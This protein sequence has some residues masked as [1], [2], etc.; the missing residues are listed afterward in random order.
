[1]S[2]RNPREEM[3]FGSD[4]FLDVV[5]NVVGILIIL[6][7]LAGIRAK[8]APVNLAEEAPESTPVETAP[9]VVIAAEPVDDEANVA[10]Q[11]ELAALQS[12]S[13]SLQQEL[14]RLRQAANAGETKLTELQSQDAVQRN[15]FKA[16][17]SNLEGEVAALQDNQQETDVLE[18]ALHAVRVR[19]K[20]RK[21]EAA[22]AEKQPNRVEKLEHR[23]TPVSRVISENETELHFRCQSSVVTTVPIEEL[24][25]RMKA[26]MERQRDVIL[27]LKKYSGSVG[28]VRGWNLNYV[29]E[30]QQLL[31]MVRASVSQFEL[32][33]EPDLSGERSEVALR[34]DSAFRNELRKAEPGSTITF[35]VYPDSFVLFR[36]LQALAHREGF[37]VAA[38]PLPEGT[39]IMGSP[40]GS[41]SAAQ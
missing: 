22:A 14:D 5:A 20:K 3:E 36:K 33:P 2:R 1:M 12:Q 11:R 21:A 41:R 15:R 31:G 37:T 28:P 26:Q 38:R 17:A 32:L 39:P 25:D 10:R 9:P 35:W 6:M 34:P 18:A 23:I 13:D 40:N 19:L 29:I 4:S 30:T 16:L 24:V 7:V 8:T 27:R